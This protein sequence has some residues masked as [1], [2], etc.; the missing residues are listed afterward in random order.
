MVLDPDD[1]TADQVLAIKDIENEILDHRRATPLRLAAAQKP[2]GCRRRPTPSDSLSSSPTPFRHRLL[3][4][5]H[6]ANPKGD[7]RGK[8]YGPV[9]WKNCMLVELD[10]C[11]DDEVY[12]DVPTVHTLY[13]QSHRLT[14]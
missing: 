12:S 4:Q 13:C 8:P 11:V 7:R 10:Y 6:N 1:P 9:R 3:S 2:P 14:V 5:R